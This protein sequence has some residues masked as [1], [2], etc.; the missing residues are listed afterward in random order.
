MAGVIG[1]TL[2]GMARGAKLVILRITNESDSSDASKMARALE[3]VANDP[4]RVGKPAI[5]K[6]ISVRH[7]NIMYIVYTQYIFYAQYTCIRITCY[8]C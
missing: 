1:S 2:Y 5:I 3:W 4:K 7:N 6:Y 8:S